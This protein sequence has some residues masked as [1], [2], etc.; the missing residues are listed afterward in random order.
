MGQQEAGGLRVKVLVTGGRGL[1]GSSVV[2]EVLKA[3][4]ECVVVQRNP[5]G[6]TGAREFL[7]DLTAPKST[8]KCL[9]GVDAVI[10]LAAKVGIV[11]SHQDF[12]EANVAATQL[13]LE[14]AKRH[15]VTSFIYASSP[16]VAHTG[17][18]LIG[19]GAGPAEPTRVRGSYSQTKARAELAV[20][21]AN[22]PSFSTL[23]LRPHLVWGPGD[24]QLI[25][26]IVARARAGRLFYIDG[27][28]ALIDTTYVSNAAQAFA[29]A[30]TASPEAFGLAHMV[31][32]GE[33]RTVRET[34][35]RITQA[36][37]VPGP[38]RSVSFH[39]AMAA[40]RAAEF[41]W[42]NRTSEPPLT[43]FLVEQLATAHWFDIEQTKKL[44]SWSPS[45]SLDEGFTELANWYGST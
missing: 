45:I 35:I 44:L 25:E 7:D 4:H 9:A 43:S 17:S 15:G 20:L 27:G 14:A 19:A 37:G 6:I 29:C 34:L 41:A 21:A 3:G 42:R 12:I 39:I 26:R 16:S 2:H 8:E 1:L 40:G 32:N 18:A 36:A 30:L 33:P 31:T 38:L 24:T 22:T 11:G 10:H 23:A 28:Y 13:L 5:A